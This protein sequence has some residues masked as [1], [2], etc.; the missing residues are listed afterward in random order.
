MKYILSTKYKYAQVIV[1]EHGILVDGGKSF[2]YFNTKPILQV[3]EHLQR[4]QKDKVRLEKIYE[5]QPITK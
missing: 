4:N 5:N 1:D 2:K 3:M